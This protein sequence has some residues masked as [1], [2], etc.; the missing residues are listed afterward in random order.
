MKDLHLETPFET[1]VEELL[2]LR[3]PFFHEEPVLRGNKEDNVTYSITI[4]K[5][6]VLETFSTDHDFLELKS[7]VENEEGMSRYIDVLKFFFHIYD[8]GK[9]DAAKG[10]KPYFSTV[11]PLEKDVMYV[12]SYLVEKKSK[13]RIKI[14]FFPGNYYQLHAFYVQFPRKKEELEALKKAYEKQTEKLLKRIQEINDK[15]KM[16][17]LLKLL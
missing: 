6:E 16:K 9:I 15:Q 1:S 11:F 3:A 2:S 13:Y 17:V 12:N 14:R 7:K 10:I 5:N 4:E 8:V